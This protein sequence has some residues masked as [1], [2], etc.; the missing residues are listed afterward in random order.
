VGLADALFEALCDLLLKS[1]DSNFLSKGFTETRA[2]FIT[3]D[4]L[5]SFVTLIFA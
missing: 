5:F 3:E 2:V 4:G 1:N